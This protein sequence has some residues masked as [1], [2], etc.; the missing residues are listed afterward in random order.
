MVVEGGVQF[1]DFGF[2]KFITNEADCCTE[3]NQLKSIV[4][5]CISTVAQSLLL[6]DIIQRDSRLLVRDQSEDVKR[7]TSDCRSLIS[8]RS[9]KA[10]ASS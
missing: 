8:E 2:S 6:M 1:I 9:L 5:N 3:L 10:H 4:Q 7:R